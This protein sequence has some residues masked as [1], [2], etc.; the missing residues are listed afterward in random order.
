MALTLT[1]VEVAN[2]DSFPRFVHMTVALDN[3]YPTGGYDGFLEKFRA[4]MSNSDTP[5][6]VIPCG[7]D[8]YGVRY[9]KTTDKLVLLQSNNAGALGPE[10]QVA[11]ATDLSAITL[12]LWIAVN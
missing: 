11:N 10:I 1:L 12:D 8:G 2:R 5:L 9:N 7:L 6:F 4:K 3:S